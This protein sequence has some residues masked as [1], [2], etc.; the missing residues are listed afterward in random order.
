MFAS[1]S[2]QFLPLP[3]V[4]LRTRVHNRQL[5]DH[6]SHLVDCCLVIRML[7]C[8][9]YR[10]SIGFIFCFLLFNDCVLRV[11]MSV[12]HSIPHVVIAV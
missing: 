9:S 5:P 7:F 10:H 3:T 1:T 4:S 11:L 2:P 12:Y 8:Q 6:L